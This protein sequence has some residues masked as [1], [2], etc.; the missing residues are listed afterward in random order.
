MPSV[1]NLE[2]IIKPASRR[3]VNRLQKLIGQDAI[4]YL[5]ATNHDIYC[6]KGIILVPDCRT[7]IVRDHDRMLLIGKGED[8][9]S[10]AWDLVSRGNISVPYFSFAFEKDIAEYE[11]SAKKSHFDRWETKNPKLV[12][13]SLAFL[14]FT[15]RF[16]TE[17]RTP[18]VI[19][20]LDKR[21]LRLFR[22]FLSKIGNPRNISLEKI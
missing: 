13:G 7:Y 6:F 12:P 22:K 21:R 11:R 9:I 14:R 4:T 16:L 15:G 2:D 20:T 19:E 5:R 8:M 17:I 1:E 3:E 10:K 18:I